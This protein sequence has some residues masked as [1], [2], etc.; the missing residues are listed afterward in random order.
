MLC[1]RVNKLYNITF[2]N[3]YLKITEKFLTMQII[4]YEY[5]LK[6]CFNLFNNNQIKIQEIIGIDPIIRELKSC[7]IIYKLNEKIQSFVMVASCNN[8]YQIL[9]GTPIYIEIMVDDNIHYFYQNC[10]NDELNLGC[11]NLRAQ[12]IFL[13]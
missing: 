9:K 1:Y 10:H 7:R 12:Q 11:S 5:N 2:K 13:S 8:L 3:N 4:P 6:Y